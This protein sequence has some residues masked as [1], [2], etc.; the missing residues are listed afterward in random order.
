MELTPKQLTVAKALKLVAMDY[1]D[2]IIDQ[3]VI[4][5]WE[6]M[7]SDIPDELIL[8]AVKV[9]KLKSQFRPKIAE[10]RQAALALLNP[11]TEIDAGQ[12]WGM[13]LKAI[14]RF[15]YSQE[16]QA[17]AALP[18]TVANAARRVGWMDLCNGEEMH[19][20]AHFLKMFE[21][22]QEREKQIGVLPP[23]LQSHFRQA[24][25]ESGPVSMSQLLAPPEKV[26]LPSAS[27]RVSGYTPP[28]NVVPFRRKPQA[29]TPE[30]L[31][32]QAEL[33]KSETT[34]TAEQAE[35]S[36]MSTE[37]RAEYLKQQAQQLGGAA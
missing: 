2:M 14:R 17:M 31:R 10:I 34:K 11:E 6:E 24:A 20:R 28:Q 18:P 25:L 5:H 36:A 12:A 19:S 7:L 27:G 37:E 29:R 22:M 16:S 35:F 30:E 13:V 32:Q 3:D 9:V 33:L 4:E 1:D 21:G 15:G 26:A 8:A 23:A